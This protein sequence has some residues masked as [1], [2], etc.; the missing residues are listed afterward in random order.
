M[1]AKLFSLA[2]KIN[3]MLQ[4]RAAGK[5]KKSADD[6]IS[7]LIKAYGILIDEDNQDRALEAALA[8]AQRPYKGV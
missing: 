3:E 5:L 7:G 4:N 6:F 1:D 2:S 8:M